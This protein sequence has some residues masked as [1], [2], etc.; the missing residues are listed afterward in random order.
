[1]ENAMTRTLILGATALTLSAAIGSAQA[2][3]VT[4]GAGNPV[5]LG[6]RIL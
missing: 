2:G 4:N 3:Y 1:M 5:L 6:G